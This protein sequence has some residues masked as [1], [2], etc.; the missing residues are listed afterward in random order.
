ME[1]LHFDGSAAERIHAAGLSSLRGHKTQTSWKPAIDDIDRLHLIHQDYHK[2]VPR[3]SYYKCA[4]MHEMQAAVTL[5]NVELLEASKKLSPAA[6]QKIEELREVYKTH[7]AAAQDARQLGYARR[8][9]LHHWFASKISKDYRD[10]F[11]VSLTLIGFTINLIW[12]AY[13][14]YLIM[15]RRDAKKNDPASNKNDSKDGVS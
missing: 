1:S 6:K 12:F 3:T 9:G 15:Q 13:I 2:A 8:S 14:A 4:R 10:H 5:G 11:T 7:V